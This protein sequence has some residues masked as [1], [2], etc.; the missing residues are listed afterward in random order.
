HVLN[1]ID[2][3]LDRRRDRFRYHLGVCARI[4]GRDL[5]GRWCDL[6]ILGNR[7]SRKR[8]HADERDNDADNAGK[9]WPIDEK[10]RKVHRA[11]P[12]AWLAVILG[13]WMA[14]RSA[15]LPVRPML[16]PPPV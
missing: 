2:L 11:W 14:W 3:L 8:D 15:S 6:G 10:V 7:K 5:N 9:D 16:P 1:A 12:S 13:L 4:V